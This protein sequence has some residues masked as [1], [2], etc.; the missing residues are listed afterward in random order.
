MLQINGR[1]GFINLDMDQACRKLADKSPFCADGLG[2]RLPNLPGPRSFFG[3]F[4]SPA[5]TDLQ[6]EGVQ[7]YGISI[8]S[9][10]LVYWRIPQAEV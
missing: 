2:G 7:I 3:Y 6:A 9:Q 4:W 10:L 1:V 8:P 5:F